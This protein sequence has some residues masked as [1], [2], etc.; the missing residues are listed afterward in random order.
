[1]NAIFTTDIDAQGIALITWN[2]PQSPVNTITQVAMQA[3]E[4]QIQQLQA[5]EQV[6]A[7]VL[8]SAK[9][10]FVVGAN[11]YEIQ[12]IEPNATALLA[13]V[14][15]VHRL[16]RSMEKGNKPI[17]AALNGTAL[18]GGL[19]IALACHYRIAADNPKARFG[20]PEV[21]LGLLPGG[22][23]T[24][25]LARLL[26]IQAA[27]PWL[28]QATQADAKTAQQAGFIDEVVPADELV[29]RA[30]AWLLAH[31]QAHVQPWDEKKFTLPKGA[32]QSAA[33]LQSLSIAQA[34]L[35]KKT[36]GLYL[37]P[38]RILQA[39]Y[40]GGSLPIDQAL[41]IEAGYFVELLLS[42]QSQVMI[43]SFFVGLQ[44]INKLKHRPK[45]IEKKRFSKIGVLGAGMMGAGIAYAAA[46][47]SL[48]VVLLDSE[49]SL[50]EKGKAYSERLLMQQQQ[51]GKI[52][53]ENA[54]AI[55]AAI[56]PTSDYNDLQQCELVIE[57]VFEDRAVKNKVLQQAQAVLPTQAMLASNTSTLPIT[58]LAQA[59]QR[60]TQFIG[61]H[62]FSPVE[63]MPLVE[64]IVGPETSEQTLAWA[65]DFVRQINKTPI[66]V[67]DSR[68]FYTT[69]VF[70]AYVQEGMALLREGVNPILID[71]AAKLAGMPVGPLALSDEVS[72]ELMQRILQQTQQD[73]GADYQPHPADK[74][75]EKMVGQL[76]RLGKK[77]A[78]G[79]YDYSP[80]KGKII[81]PGLAEHFP[82]ATQQPSV[83][84]IKQRLLY[85]Q[86]VTALHC[87]A[88]GVIS[89]ADEM[90]I[91]SIYGLGF[92]PQTGGV[93]SYIET[94]EGLE[95]FVVTADKLAKLFG[96][97]FWVPEMAREM[98]QQGQ[99]FYA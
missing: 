79:F 71:N 94:I 89:H 87:L 30:K 49:H 48:S 65:L 33:V 10:D 54:Q 8:T 51:R 5:N 86:A 19:E 77:V 37:A 52:S 88:E 28:L 27:L 45:N 58:G 59:S 55:L 61:L 22:G 23:G 82:L 9:N 34:Q 24:Q 64:V 12:R 70:C 32:V 4:Q 17:V 78:Q 60:A 72:L 41:A 21:N 25:R 50:A 99:S 36:Q 83:E 98:A 69:R 13:Y 85:A 93:L 96:E 6:Q 29:A 84:Q 20:F 1:M 68:G 76:Q 75:V 81:W 16:M 95:H 26:G 40:E 38:Q 66:V 18:G 56:Q 7:I 97:R 3:L 46:K 63:K 43:R 73:L 80:E 57:A 42:K 31:P 2:D 47:N 74:V 62:F 39:L 91:G 11:L 92:A 14:N 15:S 44:N 53:A 90:D 67:K 35:R